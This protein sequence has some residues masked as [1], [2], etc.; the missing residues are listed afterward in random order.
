MKKKPIYRR[1]LLA[2]IA[3][4]CFISPNANAQSFEKG[5][6]LI[7]MDQYHNAIVFFKDITKQAPTNADAWYYLGICYSEIE[8]VDSASIAFNAGFAADP[9]NPANLSGQAI[10]QHFKKNDVQAKATFMA[11]SRLN[12]K[13]YPDGLAS[14]IK[15]YA[16]CKYPVDEF[17]DEVKKKAQANTPN[18]TKIYLG[19]GE[20]MNNAKDY[21]NASLAYQRALSYDEKNV[22]AHYLLGKMYNAARNL[23]A[24]LA[25]IDAALELNPMFVPAIREKGDAY[26]AMNKFDEAATWYAKYIQLTE[27]TIGSL[28]KYAEVLFFDKKYEKAHEIISKILKLEPNNEIMLR[29]MGWVSYETNNDADGVNAMG[30]FF[31]LRGDSVSKILPNDY[32]YYAKLLK[33]SG[34]DSLAITYY[35]KTLKVDSTKKVEFIDT[36]GNIYLRQKR[37]IQSSQYFEM[38]QKFRTGISGQLQN[39]IGQNYLNAALLLLPADSAQKK[40][41]LA[42]PSVAFTDLLVK[43][44]SSYSRVCQSNPGNYYG[45]LSRARLANITDPD[46]TKGLA[47]LYYE[48]T[49][50]VN[51]PDKPEYNKSVTIE[52]LKYMIGVTYNQFTDAQKAKDKEKTALIKI[53]LNELL[54]KILV[55]DPGNAY[56]TENLKLLNPP[57]KKPAPGAKK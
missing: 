48:K 13:K 31:K 43:A 18:N 54:N 40:A 16:I 4:L 32:E 39:K 47:K 11:A 28:T 50:E 51:Q 35:L 7:D 38:S 57:A 23:N 25:E 37:Y 29:L 26:F 14:I 41:F 27:E 34:N 19:W 45:Y 12:Q 42:S 53:Q 6:H 49:I 44:D 5:L 8:N 9:K 2:I 24:A 36:I 55:V 30:K 17:I 20:I 3:A 10:V 22:L 33:R 46:L 52:A 21:G 56:A 15:G 1:A